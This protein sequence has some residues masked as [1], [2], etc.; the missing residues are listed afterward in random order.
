MGVAVSLPFPQSF[1]TLLSPYHLE[2]ME[3]DL[4]GTSL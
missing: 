1:S 3:G 4:G 2:G